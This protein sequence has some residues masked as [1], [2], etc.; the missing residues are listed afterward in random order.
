MPLGK[1]KSFKTCKRAVAKKGIKN[2]GAYC[3]SIE[4]TIRK[5]RAKKSIKVNFSGVRAEAQNWVKGMGD[6]V[7]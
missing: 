2:T 6:Q 1:Y 7:R 3:G 5:V 4:N